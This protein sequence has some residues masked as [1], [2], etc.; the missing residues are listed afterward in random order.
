MECP[1]TQ[2]TP[3]SC[4]LFSSLSTGLLNAGPATWRRTIEVTESKGFDSR[5]GELILRR[6]KLGEDQRPDLEE[7]ELF[8]SGLESA[9]LI[10]EKTQ[11]G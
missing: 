11:E 9:F 1:S 6:E 2:Y 10:E 3:L 8:V 5:K 7:R 4:V